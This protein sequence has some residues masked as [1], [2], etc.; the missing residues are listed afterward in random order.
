MLVTKD[1]VKKLAHLARLALHEKSFADSIVEDLSNILQF[2]H[3]ISD[4]DTS[5][6]S[7]MEHSQAETLRCREDKVTEHNVRAAMQKDIPEAY[8]AGGLYLVPKVVE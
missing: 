3:Q 1:D 5:N 4:I 2:V 7:T 6:I 8:H